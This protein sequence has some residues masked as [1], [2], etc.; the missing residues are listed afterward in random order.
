MSCLWIEQ[1]RKERARKEIHAGLIWQLVFY[2]WF[3]NKLD[4][5]FQFT[6][7]SKWWVHFDVSK[8]MSLLFSNE[9]HPKMFWKD[10]ILVRFD[11]GLFFRLW[12]LDLSARKRRKIS[13]LR[14]RKNATNSL[15]SSDCAF[16][17]PKVFITERPRPLR[18]YDTLPKRPFPIVYCVV[19]VVDVDVVG[20]PV[21]ALH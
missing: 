18:R 10:W 20:V 12:C 14:T 1:K 13:T 5:H 16:V 9:S 8:R 3:Q 2:S 15:D 19:V 17:L 4:L 21:E 7:V 6:R 11:P